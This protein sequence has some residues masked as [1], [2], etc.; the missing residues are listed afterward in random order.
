MGFSFLSVSLAALLPFRNTKS[1]GR[2]EISM[3]MLSA[4]FARC[5]TVFMHGVLLTLLIYCST[6]AD[7]FSMYF[8]FHQYVLRLMQVRSHVEWKG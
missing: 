5:I 3:L 8:F 2:L 6:A 4:P 7:I 1:F